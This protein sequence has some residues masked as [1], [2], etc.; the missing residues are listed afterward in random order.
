MMQLVCLHLSQHAHL[1]RLS[2]ALPFLV[3]GSLLLVLCFL[4]L[5]CRGTKVVGLLLLAVV[6]ASVPNAAQAMT[7]NGYVCPETNTTLATGADLSA[8]PLDVNMTYFLP[9]GTEYSVNSFASFQ[10]R[11]C[12]VGLESDRSRVVVNFGSSGALSFTSFGGIGL[13]G[14]TLVGPAEPGPTYAV[15]ATGAPLSPDGNV[16]VADVTF[17]D[18]RQGALFV[19]G[20]PVTRISNTRFLNNAG[21]AGVLFASGEDVRTELSNV[22]FRNNTAPEE[23]QP[24]PEGKS[25]RIGPATGAAAFFAS[26]TFVLKNVSFYDNFAFDG[27]AAIYASTTADITIEGRL[28]L[29][30]NRAGDRAAGLLLVDSARV[31]ITGSVCATNNSVGVAGGFASIMDQA[32]LQIDSGSAANVAN[33][34]PDTVELQGNASVLCGS[35]S[36]PSWVGGN[37]TI[38][39]PLCKCSTAFQE[40]TSSTC[41]CGAAGWDAD[42][43]TCVSWRALAEWCCEPLSRLLGLRLC[44][45]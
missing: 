34:S 36:A 41:N 21:T 22:E 37:Y 26:H 40:G 32:V 38:E 45:I 3:S 1:S 39:G 17:Q 43:C 23:E 15:L 11:I 31:H 16:G 27:G 29:V 18:F 25:D 12:F 35:S 33:N 7:I 30:G 9:A 2:L 14:M 5:R 6:A 24:N 44:A 8:V 13:Q 20:V 19:L 42:N 28:T 10:S 4:H